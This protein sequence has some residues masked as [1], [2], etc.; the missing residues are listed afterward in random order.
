MDVKE[1]NRNEGKRQ[2]REKKAVEKVGFRSHEINNSCR[3]RIAF[4]WG[5]AQQPEVVSLLFGELPDHQR[6]RACV[7]TF[8]GRPL[9]SSTRAC[10]FFVRI[11]ARA[12]MVKRETKNERPKA[13]D[14]LLSL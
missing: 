6:S 10:L 13:R 5:D 3:H 14:V 11:L 7:W 9:V 2:K 4:A 1:R 8:L 12:Q